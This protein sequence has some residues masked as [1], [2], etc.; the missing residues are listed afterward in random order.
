MDAL[1]EVGHK[2]C[3]VQGGGVLLL[4]CRPSPRKAHQCSASTCHIWVC[5]CLSLEAPSVSSALHL[6][7]CLGTAGRAA[8]RLNAQG[9]IKCTDSQGCGLC[10]ACLISD[11]CCQR[12]ECSDQFVGGELLRRVL[13]IWYWAICTHTMWCDGLD[14]GACMHACT[15]GLEHGFTCINVCHNESWVV[16]S[17]SSC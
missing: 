7:H 5:N 17:S 2:C 3:I 14:M 11:C 16:C 12:G 10:L 6:S 8:A 4:C 15:Y 13:D 1:R 9:P